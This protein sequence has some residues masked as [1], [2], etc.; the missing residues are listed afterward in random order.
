MTNK[1]QVLNCDKLST[2]FHLRKKRNFFSGEAHAHTGA[3][4]HIHPPHAILEM[5]TET[6]SG[7]YELGNI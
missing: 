6:L 7:L 5:Q 1:D 4:T 2:T 3:H